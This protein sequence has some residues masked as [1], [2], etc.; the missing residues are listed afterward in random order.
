M[1][2]ARGLPNGDLLV[3]AADH[4]E[5]GVILDASQEVEPGS[6]LYEAWLPYVYTD[7]EVEALFSRR[8]RGAVPVKERGACDAASAARATPLA[9]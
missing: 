4:R 9:G 5:D 6:E 8:E 7:A 3:P 2:R 1:T